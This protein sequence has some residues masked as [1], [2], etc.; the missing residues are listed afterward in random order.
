MPP[1]AL[2]EAR[3]A[4]GRACPLPG[5][6]QWPLAALALTWLALGLLFHADWA[7]MVRQWWDIS[8]YNHILLIPPIIAWLVWQRVG[9]L[10]RLPA[11]GWWPGLVL[12]AGALLWWLMGEFAGLAIVRQ[13]GA[14]AMLIAATLTLQGPRAGAG[15]AFPLGYMLFLVPF[16]EELMPPM[17]M[18]T[19]AI[20]VFLTRLSGIHA[21]IDGVFIDT[22]A[23]LF[24]VAEACSG[25]MF[26]V[27]M[28]AL[29][30]L[31]A[32]VCFISWRRRIGFM[33]L[34]LV[35]PILA[36]GVRAWATVYAAQFV[37][38]RRAAGFDHIVYG[39]IFFAL[40]IAAVLALSWRWFDRSRHA[41]MIDVEAIMASPRLAWLASLRIA[42][43]AALAAMA[44]MT[45]AA[46]AWAS[47]AERLA[48]PMP[49]HIDLPQVPGWH[50][51]PYAPRTP[52][53]PR[54]NG[55]DHRLLGRYA[56][57]QGHEAD[58]FF[59]LYA[60]QGT[61]RKAAGFGEGALRPDTGWS[62]QAP[63]PGFGWGRS[64][65]LLGPARI[66][67]LA[68]TTYRTGDL[69]SGSA[70]RLGLANLQDR[71]LLRA[72]P[73]MMLIVS[74]EDAPGRPAAQS[75][76]AFAQSTGPL[77]TWMDHVAR[78]R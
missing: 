1:E 48:A 15:L 63:G 41:P 72:R 34:C 29:G 11:S 37:G 31:G 30:V 17:Q 13:A 71:L 70:V 12:F 25:V 20:T 59:A 62:W 3:Q 42:D 38:A 8:T 67:R 24:N 53:E 16:G 45:L 7:A 43:S 51:V 75:V 44:A 6:W 10:A 4:S 35:V 28:F 21:T 18:I 33:A 2:A 47:Q 27:A 76:A 36:N 9:E 32:H 26:L 74:A 77:G 68:V 19:A 46:M 64:E 52:W 5:G 55:A 78:L 40:V 61:G 65:R 50:R 49:P 66:A 60:G 58:V 69:L 22:P 56:D 73:T 54:A 23:G 57:A 14:V 39:W